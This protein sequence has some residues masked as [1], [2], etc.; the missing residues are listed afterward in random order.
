MVE[1]EI[2]HPL[3][4]QIFKLLLLPVRFYFHPPLG[5][6]DISPRVRGQEEDVHDPLPLLFLLLLICFRHPAPDLD[7]TLLLRLSSCL[8]R[9]GNCGYGCLLF[10]FTP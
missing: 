8:S 2:S 9:C 5:R 7:T 10:L 4:S 6:L 1:E 3:E